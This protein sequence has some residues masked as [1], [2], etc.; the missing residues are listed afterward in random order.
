[1]MLVLSGIMAEAQ[2]S[3]WGGSRKLWTRGEGTESNPYLIESAENLAFLAYMVGKGFD[4]RGLHFKLIKDLDLSSVCGPT[5]GNW[6]PIGPFNGSFDGGNHTISN[7]FMDDSLGNVYNPGF[8]GPVLLDDSDTSYF[9]NITFDKVKV[10]T[11]A[12]FGTIVS[13]VVSGHVVIRNNTVNILFQNTSGADFQ[14]GG[15][16]GNSLGEWTGIYHNTVKGSFTITDFKSIVLGGIIGVAVG[17]VDLGSNT[18]EAV[19]I[20]KG[21][22]GAYA[23]GLAGQMR[24]CSHMREH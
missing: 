13:Q 9:E 22:G 10:R 11:S 17:A 21:E 23:G 15:I 18:N 12:V 14:A 4:T 7:L 5:V 1:M 3:V 19:I 20:A 24:R 16:V 2:T 6:E 8:F